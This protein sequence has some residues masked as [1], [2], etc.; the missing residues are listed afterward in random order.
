MIRRRLQRIWSGLA[1]RFSPVLWL[2]LWVAGMLSVADIPGSP[3]FVLSRPAQWVYIVAVGALKASV[4]YIPLAWMMRRRRL[5]VTAH[6][7]VGVYFVAALANALCYR[8]YE[9]GVTRKLFVILSQTTPREAAEFL[10]GLVSNLTSLLASPSTYAGVAVAGLAAWLWLLIPRRAAAAT[11]AML[12][13]AGAVAFGIFCASYTYGRTAHS[14]VLR[15]AKY[16][17]EVATERRRFESMLA[18]PA[19]LPSPRTVTPGAP[20]TVVVVIGES[21]SR[22]HLSLYGYPLPTSPR[23]DAMRDSLFVFTD[24][25]GSSSCTAGNMERILT[26]KKDDATS[27]DALSYPGVIDVFK[28]AGYRTWWL[29]NQERVG[30]MSNISGVLAGRADVVRYVGADDSGDAL[31]VRY[32]E[33][34]LPDFRAAMADTAASRLIFV[35]LMGSHTEY[36]MR[37][38]A[39][40]AYFSSRDEYSPG[41]PWLDKRS[42]SRRAAYDNSIRY[43][44]DV[45]GRIMDAVAS[46]PAPAVMV[47]FSDHG[48]NVYDV[49]PYSGRG[50]D[51]VRVPFVVY[52]NCAYR[53]MCP[54]ATAALGAA[55]GRPFSTANVVYA[56]MTLT[57][58]GYALYDAA[59]DVLSPDFRRRVRMVDEVAWDTQTD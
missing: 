23:M 17:A 8:F 15:T 5:R 54:D 29:S 40:Y 51:Y 56:L 32:D 6:V 38:P 44:D 13:M 42:A 57:G 31:A 47:Y 9:F 11:A 3:V 59:D 30:A 16:M 48:E 21:A 7:L 58:T 43:T 19:V 41:L 4:L 36:D 34:L 18:Q 25:I 10:P 39:E 20:V 28:A 27:G 12:T 1:G 37:Y 45:L 46:S 14:L 52:A 2:V 53:R 22:D 55:V 26:F 50:R 33:A 35:H 49:G 24:A